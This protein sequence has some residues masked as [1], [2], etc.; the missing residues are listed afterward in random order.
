MLR[1]TFFS[2]I[3]VI[4]S[5]FPSGRAPVA[6]AV[7]SVNFTV[8][9]LDRSIEFYTKV[10][11]FRKVSERESA[12]NDIEHLTGVFGTRV[13]TARL[14]LGDEY[15][16]LTE[17]LAPQGLPAPADARSNDRWF[18]HVAIIVRDMDQ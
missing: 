3:L 4:S 11:D 6:T 13:R 15:V 2:A 9:D 16:D 18:Q 7:E 8:S 10:L 14:Q 17:Y 12:G 1:R 5:A